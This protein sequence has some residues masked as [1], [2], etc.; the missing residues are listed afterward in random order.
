MIVFDLL[1]LDGVDLRLFER[2]AQ[3]VGLLKGCAETLRF[4]EH[5][6][7][8]MGALPSPDEYISGSK[9]GSQAP[10]ERRAR[11]SDEKTKR[12]KGARP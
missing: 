11:E 3:L 1:F 10:S 12:A 6:D 4:S 7:G 8:P 9:R 5:F 2:R